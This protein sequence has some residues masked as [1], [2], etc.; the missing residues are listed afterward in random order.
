MALSLVIAS[1]KLRPCFQAYAIVVM[2]DQPIKKAMNQLDI[3]GHIIQW[4]V[5]LSQFDIKYRPRTAIEA[6]ILADFIVELTLPIVEEEKKNEIWMINTNGS[7]TKD[8][9]IPRKRYSEICC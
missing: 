5:E 9:N 8:P 2:I 4:A 7:S 1:R 3:V 6:Q